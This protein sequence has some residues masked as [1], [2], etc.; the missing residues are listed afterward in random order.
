VDCETGDC[1]GFRFRF[2]AHA[3]GVVH[4]EGFR[5]C[6]P[7]DLGYYQGITHMY[8]RNAVAAIVVY[9]IADRVTFSQLDF[10]QTSLRESAPGNVLIFLVGNKVDLE[11]NRQV[12]IDEGQARATEMGASFCELSAKAGL[13]IA[14][15]ALESG[16][17][18]VTETTVELAGGAAAGGGEGARKCC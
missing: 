5:Q 12:V 3:W 2:D 15:Q 6:A 18:P 9:S 1:R 7:S 17:V 8:Y 4:L 11:D 10:W 16:P 14:T 13:G